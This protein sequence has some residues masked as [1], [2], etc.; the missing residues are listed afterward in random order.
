MA[1]RSVIGRLVKNFAIF[2][3]FVISICLFYVRCACWFDA[4]EVKCW[5]SCLS[6]ILQMST[7]AI[8]KRERGSSASVSAWGGGVDWKCQVAFSVKGKLAFDMK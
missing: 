8:G 7:A 2:A 5:G 3:I 1:S 4:V 6:W